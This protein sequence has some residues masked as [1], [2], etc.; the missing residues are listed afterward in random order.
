MEETLNE[1]LNTIKWIPIRERQGKWYE[2]YLNLI[3]EELKLK[4]KITKTNKNDRIR[5]ISSS[6]CL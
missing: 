2:E 5:K 3:F 4:N 1:L 6:K